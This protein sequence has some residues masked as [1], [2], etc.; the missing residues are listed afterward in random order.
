MIA[1]ASNDTETGF[2]MN[3]K[4]QVQ[5]KGVFVREYN[6]TKGD[7][8]F[9]SD[10][11]PVSLD[12]TYSGDKFKNIEESRER[13]SKYVFPRRLSYEDRRRRVFGEEDVSKKGSF[14]NWWGQPE[15][16]VEETSVMNLDEII[17]QENVEVDAAKKVFYCRHLKDEDD[18]SDEEDE[19]DDSCSFFLDWRRIAT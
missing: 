3:M 11:L 10:S 5:W 19:E 18:E 6:S 17:E 16:P 4:K 2:D 12:W 8:P 7:H 14:T 1:Y 13:N 9:C 15:K